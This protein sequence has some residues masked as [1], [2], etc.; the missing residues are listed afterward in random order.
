M[1]HT[2]VSF[3]TYLVTFSILMAL[4]GTTVGIAYVDLG[5]FNL[6]VAMTIAVGK[7]A[8]II[9]FFMHVRYTPKLTWVFAGAGFFWLAFLLVLAMCD[10]ATRS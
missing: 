4:L 8:L 2:I 3:K 10:Y 6:A 5:E 7:A 1:S 9:L